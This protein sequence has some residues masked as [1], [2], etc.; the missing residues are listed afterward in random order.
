MT[1]NGLVAAKDIKVGDKVLSFD[2]SEKKQESDAG[3][4]FMWDSNSLTIEDKKPVE[5]E[6]V[7]VIEKGDSAIIYFN[8][9]TESKYSITQ[10]VFIRSGDSYKIRTT[11]SIEVGDF[12]VNV[13][14]GGN[15]TEEEVLDITIEEELGT[16][17]QIDCEP[18]QWF[19]A[20]G[21]LVH[22]K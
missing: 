11:G 9:N 15:I 1:A 21:Y 6:V 18:H 14:S 5:T 4:L 7:R 16:V 8:E 12:I 22:N 2:I 20:G 10:P 3:V 13:D 17:Y 19:I